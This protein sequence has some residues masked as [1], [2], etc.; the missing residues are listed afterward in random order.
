MYYWYT[1]A[2]GYRTCAPALSQ[3]DLYNMMLEHGVLVRK[4]PI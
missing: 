2:D 4:F 3:N 1:F